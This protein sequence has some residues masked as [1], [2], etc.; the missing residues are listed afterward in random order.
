MRGG[1]GQETVVLGGL[2][3]S[4]FSQIYFLWGKGQ[5]VA[6]IGR[7]GFEVIDWR[8]A[9]SGVNAF[10]MVEISSL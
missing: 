3:F 4:H 9:D 10:W 2:D 1:D 7:I 8:G 5:K 6:G